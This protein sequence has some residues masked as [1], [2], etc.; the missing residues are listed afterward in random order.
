MVLGP[1]LGGLTRT[2]MAFIMRCGFLPRPRDSPL[3]TRPFEPALR[4]LLLA[5]LLLTALAPASAWC[6]TA[7]D[8]SSRIR[9]DGFTNDFS[10]DEKIFGF[11]TAA[12]LPEEASDDS[13]WDNNDINQIRITWD[14]KNLYLAGEGITY[15]NNMVLFIDSVPARGL[16]SMSNLNSWKR[17]F[18]FDTTSVNGDGGFSPDLFAATWDGNPT[19]RLIVQQSGSQ[20]DD[21]V[22]G[23]YFRSA[24]TFS[25]NNRGRAMELAIPWRSV[26]LGQVGLGTHDT[27]LTVNGVTDTFRV[28]PKGTKLKICGVITG[29]GDNSGGPESAP[30]NLRGHT[31][32]GSAAV[33]LDNYAIVDLDR[34]DDTGL[35][36][37]GP[38]GIADWN[39][40]PKSRVTFR[41]QPPITP[42]RFALRAIDFDR[43]A[44]APDRGDRIHFTVELD[45]KLNPNSALDRARTVNLTASV[46]DLHG[47][48]VRNLYLNVTRPA[49]A[50]SDAA[51]DL[52]DGRDERGR[53]VPA[54]IYILRSVIEP[55]LS[56]ETRAFVVVR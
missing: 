4:R 48:F 8:L 40:E 21:E 43:P 37:G 24:A 15:G 13:K 46:F 42:L 36:N 33:L 27:L 34:N 20:V 30:D 23:G 11:N 9:I 25:T 32:D 2:V 29:G 39:V 52:W 31:S 55:S 56:R 12:G 54:G 22:S 3:S 17:N 47:G 10:D 35:G 41:Y 5:I 19:P 26:F 50:P 53:I 6:V 45:K 14:A 1:L 7:R 51:Q 38:D 44:F 28:F 18:T 16:Q 49:V